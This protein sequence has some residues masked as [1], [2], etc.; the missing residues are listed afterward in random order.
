M[1]RGKSIYTS[2]AMKSILENL[3]GKGEYREEFNS[4]EKLMAQKACFVSLHMKNGDLR[5]CI[6]TL[7]PYRENLME[8][9]IGN[10]KSAAFG[11]PRFPPLTR[12]EVEEIEVSVDILDKP[13]RI[14]KRSQLDPKVYGVIVKKGVRRGVLLPDLPG[15]TDIDEQIQ[16]A[17]SK[18]GI[19]AQEE[20][21]L[22]RFKVKRYH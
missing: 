5:G 7:E 16:I 4:E 6:G 3:G 15:V 2:L 10:A 14:E 1:Y 22:Y 11:D 12:E 19:G 20:V 8:E 9:I 18:A 13:E 17:M 21:E